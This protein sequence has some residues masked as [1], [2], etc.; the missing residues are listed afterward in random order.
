MAIATGTTVVLA[1][2]AP[3]RLSRNAAA[4]LNHNRPAYAA[5]QAAS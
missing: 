2:A 1:L 4:R 5:Y 3:A